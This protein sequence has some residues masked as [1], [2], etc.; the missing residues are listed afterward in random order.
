MWVLQNRRGY[1]LF[2]VKKNRFEGGLGRIPMGFDR[3]VK[4]FFQLTR[5]EF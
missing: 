3:G 2:D 5:R 4:R 1:K